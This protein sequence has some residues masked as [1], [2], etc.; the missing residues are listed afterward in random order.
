M[1]EKRRWIRSEPRGLVSRTGKIQLDDTAAAIECR[2]VDLSA[3]GACLEFSE[4]PELPKRFKFLHG[5][6]RKYCKV[7]WIRGYRIGITYEA[8]EQRSMIVGGLSRTT[9]VS[10]L[11]R[12]RR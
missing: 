11:S 12:G 1:V 8:I 3:G 4:I 9:G 2:I 5:G 10:R 7:A 6:T